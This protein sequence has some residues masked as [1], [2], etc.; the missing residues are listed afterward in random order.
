MTVLAGSRLQLAFEQALQTPQALR[1]AED[2]FER[3]CFAKQ[4][5]GSAGCKGAKC[6]VRHLK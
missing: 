5:A 4:H 2:G 1:V 3:L 6:H